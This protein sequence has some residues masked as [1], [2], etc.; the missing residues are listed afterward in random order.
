MLTACRIKGFIETSLLDWP[1]RIAAVVFLP[2]CNFRCPFCHNHGLVLRP[3]SVA[4]VPVEAALESLRENTGWVDGVVVTGGEPTLSTGLEGL[5][6]LFRAE[7][8]GIKLDTN[9]SN[10]GVLAR[11]IG[12]GFVDAVAMDIKAPLTRETY[13]LASGV[14]VDVTRIAASIASLNASGLEVTYRATVVPGLHDEDTVRA[15]ASAVGGMRLVLQDFRPDDALAPEYR[16]IR[17][18]GPDALAR[19]QSVADGR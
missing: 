8:I 9:G 1:G 10:P 19:L 13:S 12:G 11:L 15:M 5:L 18:F 6:R 17:P 7:G 4:D 16:L 2:G 14:E 3:D